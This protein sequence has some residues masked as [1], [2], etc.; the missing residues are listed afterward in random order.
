M[1]LVKLEMLAAYAACHARKQELRT[2][3]NAAQNENELN[4]I[5]IDWSV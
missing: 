5:A 3:I 4:V 2:A 1:E